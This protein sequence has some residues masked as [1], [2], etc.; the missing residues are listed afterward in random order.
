MIGRD[1]GDA[2]EGGKIFCYGRKIID[3]GLGHKGRHRMQTAV[4]ESRGREPAF[5]QI[6]RILTYDGTYAID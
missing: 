5:C 1:K 6:D 4:I 2:I 3:K